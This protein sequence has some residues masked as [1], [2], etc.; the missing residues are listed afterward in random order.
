MVFMKKR[1][2]LKR[3]SRNWKGVR[4][5]RK[6]LAELNNRLE[7]NTS[8]IS[9]YKML[10]KVWNEPVE[11]KPAA[12]SRTMSELLAQLRKKRLLDAKAFLGKLE[13][14]KKLI[15]SEIA[16]LKTKKYSL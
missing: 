7:A 11:G 3:I 10:L 8:E 12:E 5:S 15:L 1:P 9:Y 13:R 4:L 2:L 6:R 14:E 16:K